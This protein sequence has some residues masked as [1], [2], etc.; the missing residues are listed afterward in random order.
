MKRTTD[1]RKKNHYVPRS[2]LHRFADPKGFLHIFDRHTK[3]WRWERPEKVMNIRYYYRQEWAPVGTD[4]DLIEKSVSEWLENSAAIVI[5]RLISPPLELA[6]EDIANFIVYLEF[7]R[8]RVPR[9]IEMGKRLMRDL[10]L[11]L[12]PPDVTKDVRAGKLRLEMKRSAGFIYMN[13]MIGQFHPWFFRMKW[14]VIKA[15][16]GTTFLTTDSPL[17]LWNAACLPPAEPGI[18]LLGTVVLFPLSS[19]YLLIM[20][21]PECH[22]KTRGSSLE[23][24]PEPLRDEVLLPVTTGRIWSKKMVVNH[25][26]TMVHLSDRF[27][28]GQSKEVLEESIVG[29]RGC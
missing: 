7:Q 26:R 4:Q 1:N 8:I 21:H 20:R 10:I 3:K 19:Q 16:E 24:L 29:V 5:D 12:G 18:G 25:N 11:R 27:I 15:E 22:K 17:S 14:E 28:V 13:E 23:V 2:Y 6:E 9:Q